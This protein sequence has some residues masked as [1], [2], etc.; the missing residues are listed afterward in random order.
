[1]LNIGENLKCELSDGIITVKK[2]IGEGTQGIVYLIETESGDKIVKWYNKEQ[3][4]ELQKENIRKLVTKGPIKGE[5]GK[6]FVWPLDLV[7]SDLNN[8]FGYLMDYINTGDFAELGEVWAHIKP[9]PNMKQKCLISYNLANSYRK[10]HLEGYCYRD[11]S[12][13]NLMFNPQ[14]GDVLICDNDNIGVNN[15]SECQILGTMEYMAPEII[16]NDASP[17]TKTDLHSLAVLLFQLWMWHHPMHG[18]MEYNFRSWDIPAKKKVYGENP[19]FV[20]D[21]DNDENR[22]PDDYEYDTPRKFWEV[23]PGVLKDLFIKA[24][25]EG[26]KN[27]DKRIT[28]GEWEKVFLEL[29]DNIVSCPNDGA[30]NFW[31]EGIENFRCWYCKEEINRPISISFNTCLGRQTL[32]ITLETKILKRNIAPFA[33]ESDKNLVIAEI[34]QNPKNPSIWGIRNLNSY[35]LKYLIKD[36]TEKFADPQKAIPISSAIDKIYFDNTEAELIIS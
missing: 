16:M 6:R 11:I 30:E 32:A 28:E 20:F 34:V 7:T 15:Q 26:L 8:S 33:E 22:L 1:M 35:P 29:Y 13:G 9:T 14:T 36:G 23:C 25:T 12:S 3:A 2:K 27:P 24:F 4:T 31:Y 18:E 19:V 5:A 21:P 17:S 10:L